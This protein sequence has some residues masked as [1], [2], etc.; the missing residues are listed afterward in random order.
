MGS[1]AL[2]LASGPP[3]NRIAS[4]GK[5]HHMSRGFTLI[6]LMI[7]IVVVSIL[8]SMAVPAYRE[9]VAKTRRA[10]AQAS[11]MQLGNFMERTFT[12]NGT[13]QP[14][15]SSP[16]LPF[17]ESPQDGS[18]KFYDL[19]IQAATGNSFTLRATPKNGQ[20]GDG[21]VELQ[22]TGARFWDQDNDGAVD[23]GESDWRSG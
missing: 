16:A 10:D 12:V 20:A 8:A 3:M 14:G 15:G 22:H 18:P 21:I 6:E 4:D 5:A 19:T 9:H 13:Y 2:R 23:A 1:R 7:V 11:L 17:T